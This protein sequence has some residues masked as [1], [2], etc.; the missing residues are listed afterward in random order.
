MSENSST[1]SASSGLRASTNDSAAALTAVGGPGHA[2]AGV[3][4]EHDRDRRHRFLERVHLLR[5]P[6]FDHHEI[7]ARQVHELALLASVAVNSSDGRTGGGAGAKYPA[8]V[9]MRCDGS[10]VESA[11]RRQ[12]PSAAWFVGE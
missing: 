2:A 1:P 7:V 6:V 3:E 5:D 9:R 10:V 8:R 11:I 4:R 12:A